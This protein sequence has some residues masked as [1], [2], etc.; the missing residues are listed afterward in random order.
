MA[1][2]LVPGANLGGRDVASRS[3]FWKLPS[4]GKR[5]AVF[6]DAVMVQPGAVLEVDVMVQAG[7]RFRGCRCGANRE[8]F[9][10]ME[11]AK[12]VLRAVSGQGRRRLFDRKDARANAGRKPKRRQERRD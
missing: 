8:P 7:G 6:G 9:S 10:G 11:P 1:G 12:A 2:V 5:V 3:L 4:W